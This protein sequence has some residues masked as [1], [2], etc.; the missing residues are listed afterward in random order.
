MCCIPYNSYTAFSEEG[1]KDFK[2]LLGNT[3]NES[4][5]VLCAF[6]YVSLVMYADHKTTKISQFNQLTLTFQTMK[7]TGQ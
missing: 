2:L 4:M 6:T 1:G 5:S 7:L 3:R